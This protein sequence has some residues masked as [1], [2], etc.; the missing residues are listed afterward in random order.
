MSGYVQL[1][2]GLPYT[3]GWWEARSGT[4][5]ITASEISAVMGLSPWVSPFTL[6]HR[7]YGTIRPEPENDSM[8]WG[9]RLEQAVADE[10]SS[11]HEELLVADAGVYRSRDRAYQ[12][13][14]P[15]RLLLRAKRPANLTSVLE[16]KTTQSLDGWGEEGTDSIPVHYRAQVLWQ[17]DTLGLDVAHVAVLASGRAYRE[18][19][20]DYHEADLA[21]MRHA[22]EDFLQLLE[23]RDPPPVDWLPA[24]TSTLKQLHPTVSDA[25]VDVGEELGAAYLEAVNLAKEADEVKRLMENRVRR[26]LG[27]GRYAYAA[28]RKVATRSVYDLAEATITRRATRVNRLIPVRKGKVPA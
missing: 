27:D 6:W 24:T 18:Y 1:Y 2:S 16:V 11:L 14:S 10:F 8:R 25:E 9:L 21:V 5:V 19:Q 3:P 17:L 28:G 26:A 7:K 23:S 20:I 12:V 4:G 15:D 13:A 22:A